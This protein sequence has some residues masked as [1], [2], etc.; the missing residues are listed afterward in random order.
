[1]SFLLEYRLMWALWGEG[2]RPGSRWQWAERLGAGLKF[3]GCLS[4]LLTLVMGYPIWLLGQPSPV[5]PQN[6]LSWHL[7]PLTQETLTPFQL[8]CHLLWKAFPDYP[9]QHVPSCFKLS[10]LLHSYPS[11]FHICDLLVM[12]VTPPDSAPKGLGSYVIE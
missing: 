1:M 11:Q 9:N 8:T 10:E 12:S 4:V 5:N 7:P 2:G 3:T 6:Y